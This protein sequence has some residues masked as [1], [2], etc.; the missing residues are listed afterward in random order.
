MFEIC[1]TQ[2]CFPG[3]ESTPHVSIKVAC[4]QKMGKMNQPKSKVFLHESLMG[5]Q[6]DTKA[7]QLINLGTLKFGSN[8]NF[9]GLFK[10]IMYLL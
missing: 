10:A 3:L 7:N 4:C 6:E 5:M 2:V 1:E 9:C 8:S